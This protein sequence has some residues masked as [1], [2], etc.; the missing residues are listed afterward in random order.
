MSSDKKIKYYTAADIEKYHRGLLSAA[1]QHALEKAAL[2]DP[3]LADALEGYATAGLNTAADI[4]DLKKRLAEKTGTGSGTVVPMR[5]QP[6]FA[7]WRAAAIIVLLAGTAILVYRLAFVNK[8]QSDIVLQ[9]QETKSLSEAESKT[10]PGVST[11]NQVEK[12]SEEIEKNNDS[13]IKQN[14]RQTTQS[15]PLHSPHELMQSGASSKDTA[16]ITAKTSDIAVMHFSEPANRKSTAPEY[17]ALALADSKKQTEVKPD[18]GNSGIN[19]LPDQQTQGIMARQKKTESPRVYYFRGRITDS[20]SNPL[21][22][23][24]ITNM[25]DHVGTYSDALGNFTLVSTDSVLDVQVRS[26]GYEKNYVRMQGNLSGITIMLQQ[27]E[28]IR[29]TVLSNYRP[30]AERLQQL[31]QANISIEEPAPVDGWE[32]Y[33]TYLVNNRNIPDEKTKNRLQGQVELTF[34]VNKEGQPINFRIEKSLCKSC[35]EEAIRLIKEGPRWKP[36]G[37]KRARVTIPFDD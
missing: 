2:D 3:M 29:S 24:N 10:N 35:D 7:W 32:N 8:K 14:N 22:F 17:K 12:F 13:D 28:S 30:N 15:A 27:D 6:L 25:R 36:K 11:F 4:A 20:A 23:A 19:E 31:R 21:P 16:S 9:S 26:L 33:D 5:R 1:E 37:K 18:G 34:E